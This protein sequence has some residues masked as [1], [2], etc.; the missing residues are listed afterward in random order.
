MPDA[1]GPATLETAWGDRV[2]ANRDQ[3]DRFR[4][5]AD[6]RDFYRP[7]SQL[8]RADPFREGDSL[9]AALLALARPDDTWLDIGAGAGR[10]AL[11]LARTAR[12]VIAFDSSP[13]MLAALRDG[14]ATSGIAN[15]EVIHGWWPDD[16]GDLRADVALIAHV[17]YDVEAI[18]PFLAAME[19]A[20]SRLCVAVMMEQPPASLAAPFWPPIHGEERATLPALPE[21]VALLTAQGR[22]VAVRRIAGEARRLGT[23]D[24]A[25][26]FLRQQLW[27]AADSAK[28]RRLVAMVDALPRD[29]DGAIRLDSPYRDIGIVTWEP[30]STTG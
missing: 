26:A 24:E 27:V 4:E 6:G 28:G 14:M 21:L 3:V 10:F 23:V 13:G 8:F 2:R 29:P 17:G 20:A 11:P 9:L 15:V 12:R 30:L 16:A 22:Q 1:A 25:L 5:V 7:T 18:G 19:A